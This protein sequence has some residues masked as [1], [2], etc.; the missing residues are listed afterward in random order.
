MLNGRVT[1]SSADFAEGGAFKVSRGS[2]HYGDR[3]MLLARRSYRD[4]DVLPKSG[5]KVHETLD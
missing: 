2:R 3:S 5:E 1:H 4:L